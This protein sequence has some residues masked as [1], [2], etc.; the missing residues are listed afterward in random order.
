MS[1]IFAPHKKKISILIDF[2]FTQAAMTDS[3]SDISSVQLK[4]GDHDAFENKRERALREILSER[5]ISNVD[6]NYIGGSVVWE[7]SQALQKVGLDR[8]AIAVQDHGPMTS[9]LGLP[10]DKV[11]VVI[12]HYTSYTDADIASYL[13]SFSA[14]SVSKFEPQGHHSYRC[15]LTVIRHGKSRWAWKVWKDRRDTP[16]MTCILE[17][18]KVQS[19]IRTNQ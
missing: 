16:T 7:F 15:S 13:K 5:Y 18:V 19:A 3:F 10:P 6:C 11:C 9:G 17:I 14:I 12:T 1:Q 8:S 4:A 2:S